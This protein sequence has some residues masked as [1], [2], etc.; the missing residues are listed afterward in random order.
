MIAGDGDR[1]AESIR[2][3]RCS[4]ADGRT[5]VGALRFAPF[6]RLRRW[7]DQFA[8]GPTWSDDLVFLTVVVA[9]LAFGLLAVVIAAVVAA[10]AYN[11]FFLSR[12]SPSLLPTRRT[13]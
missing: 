9:G 7:L 10:L 4:L 2:R 8:V 5:I 1:A 11:F 13:C 6:G 3:G 12:V